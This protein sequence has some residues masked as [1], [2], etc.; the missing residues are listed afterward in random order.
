RRSA[1]AR[2]ECGLL[3]SRLRLPSDWM[4]RSS[5]LSSGVCFAAPPGRNALASPYTATGGRDIRRRRASA[6]LG[7]RLRD[8]DAALGLRFQ[9]RALP[10]L[11]PR[12]GTR[13]APVI[14]R[15]GPVSRE[16]DFHRRGADVETDNG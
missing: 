3:A 7:Q 6:G 12:L 1:S 16:N 4:L 2:S 13:L 9:G 11:G 10:S 14:L 5:S 15:R 8:Q